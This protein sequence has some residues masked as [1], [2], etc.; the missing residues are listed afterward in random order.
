MKSPSLLRLS[1]P[2]APCRVKIAA[3]EDLFLLTIECFRYPRD[4]GGHPRRILQPRMVKV[5]PGIGLLSEA[6]SYIIASVCVVRV[7]FIR[8]IH[9]F[10]RPSLPLARMETHHH[11][12]FSSPSASSGSREEP[13]THLTRP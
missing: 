6:Q 9:M 5:Q 7:A 2:R 1:L 12:R 11:H 10:T 8:S 4:A 3:G 13:T